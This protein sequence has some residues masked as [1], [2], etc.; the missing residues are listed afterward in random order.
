M[1]EFFARSKP[2]RP[3][4]S[5]PPFIIST[6]GIDPEAARFI[7]ECFQSLPF[8]HA[9]LTLAIAIDSAQIMVHENRN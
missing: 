9:T 4:L 8:E 3:I 2:Q 7:V 1:L 6:D 5:L